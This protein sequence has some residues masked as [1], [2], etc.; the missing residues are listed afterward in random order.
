M[1]EPLTLEQVTPAQATAWLD[2]LTEGHYRNPAPALVDQFAAAMSAGRWQPT[3]VDPIRIDVTGRLCGGR[4]R[5]LAVQRVGVPVPMWVETS[6][7]VQP[8]Q[9]QPA[10]TQPRT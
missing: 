3:P 9:R 2:T 7:P 1:T 8:Q 5:L 10:S 4:M 6:P